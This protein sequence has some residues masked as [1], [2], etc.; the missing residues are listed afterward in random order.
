MNEVYM[1]Q[2]KEK[3]G[4]NKEFGILCNFIREKV[5]EDWDMVFAVTG[6]E[7]SSKSTCIN[8]MGFKIDK[9]YS[10]SNNILYSPNR[11]E[12]KDK[13][14]GL[15]RFSMVNADEAIKIL[16]K[17]QWHSPMQIF[18]NKLYRLCRQENKITGLAM[19]RFSDFNEGF[20]NHRIKIWIYC[21]EKGCAVVF[22]PDWS[23]FAKDPWWMDDNQK[24]L[25]KY[26]KGRKLQDFTL[27]DKIR[28]L[29]SSRNYWGVITYPDLTEDMR[30][31]YKQ[32]ANQNKY[33]GLEEEFE[34]QQKAN[35][36]ITFYQKAMNLA[37][38]IIRD[39]Q[40]DLSTKDL[41]K[42]LGISHDLVN[43]LS[44]PIV[45]DNDNEGI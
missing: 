36:Y 22:T 37:I 16:Y 11:Q 26:R 35:K 20:R 12:L 21:L 5:R 32:F 30:L 25:D 4:Y 44:K 23:P 29:M 17:A 34:E 7:G 10:L 41:G 8:Q 19:P 31:Q 1:P 28:V 38:K 18:I 9:D 42:M 2:M 15:P 39:K 14:I 6:A 27:E 3:Y 33:G 43:N 45:N 24:M 13:V 40:P